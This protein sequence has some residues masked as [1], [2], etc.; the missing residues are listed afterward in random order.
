MST[1]RPLAGIHFRALGPLTQ[2]RLGEVQ[3][4]RDLSH[5]GTGHLRQAHRLGLKLRRERPSF[6][7]SHEQLLA[8]LRAFGVVHKPGGGSVLLHHAPDDEQAETDDDRRATG[9]NDRSVWRLTGA[10]YDTSD[11]S[12]YA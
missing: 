7:S 11:G 1:G 8:H 9:K 4:L 12:G 3:V 10:P 5:G 6:P 2:R